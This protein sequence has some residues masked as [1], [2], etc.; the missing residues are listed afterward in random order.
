GTPPRGY[1][2]R[3]KDLNLALRAL[4]HSGVIKSAHDCSEGGL[5]V[6]IAESCVSQQVAR[7][8]PA[9][10]G[11]E[12]DLTSEPD[13]SEPAS[14][15]KTGET[16]PDRTTTPPAHLTPETRHSALPPRVDALLFG[17]SQARIVTSVSA[18]NAVKVLAQAKIL[19]IPA[20][21][22]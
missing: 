1:L 11:A 14:E 5:A 4:I 15:E 7:E 9:L 6:A 2:E 20:V 17:E 8:T 21:R 12:I 18:I 16:P 13:V 22:I 3:E 19:G 10:I